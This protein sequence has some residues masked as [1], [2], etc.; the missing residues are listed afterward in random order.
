MKSKKLHP[1]P[2]V[3]HEESWHRLRTLGPTRNCWFLTKI[4]RKKMVVLHAL[5]QCYRLFFFFSPFLFF[6]HPLST[7]L[8]RPSSSGL[9]GLHRAG[10]IIRY[11]HYVNVW[12]RYTLHPSCSAHLFRF[13]S[14]ALVSLDP[15]S[16]AFSAYFARL[17]LAPWQI[18]THWLRS[19]SG[20]PGGPPSRL[21]MAKTNRLPHLFTHECCNNFI[22]RRQAIPKSTAVVLSRSLSN[23]QSPYRD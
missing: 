8:Q 9:G 18:N 13:N 11:T 14:I 20:T 23:R 22:P 21:T 16:G 15:C 6:L 5:R 19:P 7:S 4:E 1:C 3:I 17:F 12:Y 10:K 2:A